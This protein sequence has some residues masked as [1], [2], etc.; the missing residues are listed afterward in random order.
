M[1]RP[2]LITKMMQEPKE[3]SHCS[4]ELNVSF[5]YQ[6]NSYLNSSI[7]VNCEFELSSG[8]QIE[9]SNFKFRSSSFSCLSGAALSANATLANTNICNGLI[10]EE[11]LPG[12]DSPRSFRRMPSSPSLSSMDLLSSSH[13]SISTLGGSMS[14]D[15]DMLETI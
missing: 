12:L 2:F 14:T 7:K 9:D 3:S 1:R 11:I 6:C 4:G 8:I 5:G 15:S 10:G 13:S